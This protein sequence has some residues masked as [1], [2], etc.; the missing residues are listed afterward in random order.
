MIKRIILISI[1]SSLL[2]SCGVKAPPEYEGNDIP[3]PMS[4]E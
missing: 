1:F 3:V 4:V 2:L